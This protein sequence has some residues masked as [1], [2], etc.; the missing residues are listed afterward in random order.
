[1]QLI[2]RPHVMRERTLYQPGFCSHFDLTSP[3]PSPSPLDPEKTLK[4][5]GLTIIVINQ[6]ENKN[7][8]KCTNI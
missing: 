3:S 2:L 6:K 8:L 5:M 7:P 1:M 4:P